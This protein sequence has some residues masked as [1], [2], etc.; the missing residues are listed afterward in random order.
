MPPRSYV[1][2]IFVDELSPFVG[3]GC[4]LCKE[5]FAPGDELVVCPED[6]SRH[7]IHCWEA[8]NNHCTAYGCE[9]QAEV[10]PRQTVHGPRPTA[11][12]VIEQAPEGQGSKVRA[13]PT[14]SMGCAQSCLIL[15][16]ALAILLIAFS[17]YGLWAMLDYVLLEEL[18]WSYRTPNSG[19]ILPL[20][21]AAFVRDL[22]LFLAL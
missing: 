21:F 20:F 5:P 22:P 17:C 16:I 1:R 19:M 14:S 15:S 8:N 6:G 13:L 7:H 2:P 9:G 4:A 18:G 12:Q 10:L 11:Q 3:E